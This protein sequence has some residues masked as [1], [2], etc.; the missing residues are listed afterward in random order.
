MFLDL[1]RFRHLHLNV[2]VLLIEEHRGAI[3]KTLSRRDSSP[4]FM[5]NSLN[6]VC[7]I[8]LR[9]WKPNSHTARP[10]SRYTVLSLNDRPLP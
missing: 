7:L 3:L 4:W 6:D 9:F 10:S 8:N 1:R 5:D 2:V